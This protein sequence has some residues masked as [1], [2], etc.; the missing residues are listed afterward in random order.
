MNGPTKELTLV[1][2]IIVL[3]DVFMMSYNFL[4]NPINRIYLHWLSG[5][6]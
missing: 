4:E 2:V 6:T 3:G 5:G 1:L